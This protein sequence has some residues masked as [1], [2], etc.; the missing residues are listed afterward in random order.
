MVSSTWL[1]VRAP[2]TKS[3][4]DFGVYT[5]SENTNSWQSMPQ[6]PKCEVTALPG[7]GVSPVMNHRRMDPWHFTLLQWL[8]SPSSSQPRPWLQQKGKDLAALPTGHLPQTTAFRSDDFFFSVFFFNFNF[9]KAKLIVCEMKEWIL[10]QSYP[11][12]N[13]W[14][15]ATE[16]PLASAMEQG[17]HFFFS[18]YF[19]L[20]PFSPP[21]TTRETDYMK[22]STVK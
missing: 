6:S 15:F 7:V 20:L 22:K 3:W 13:S 1:I 17:L 19:F 11:S 10:Q 4:R 5:H 18:E 8:L 12:D 2:L 21:H 9:N 16:F 14:Q